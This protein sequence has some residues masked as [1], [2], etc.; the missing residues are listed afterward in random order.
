MYRISKEFKFS[1]GHRLSC[2]QGLCKNFHGHNYTVI[3][4]LKSD[5][6]NPNGMVMDFGDLKAIAQNYFKGL[7]HAMMIHSSDADKFMKLQQVMPFLK[8]IV[9]EYEPTAENMAK[10]MFE[11]FQTEVSKY[12]GDIK[13]D[14]ITVYETDSSQATYSED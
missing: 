8:V 10:A 2:H 7:D 13:V 11:Y 12:A 3:I 6:L 4:G 14:F 1:M 5:N 9:V